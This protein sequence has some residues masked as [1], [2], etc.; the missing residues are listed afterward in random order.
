MSLQILVPLDGSKFAEQALPFARDLIAQTG[1]ILHL[2]K[3]HNPVESRMSGLLDEEFMREHDRAYLAEKVRDP[4]L[5]GVMAVSALL[6]GD[7]VSALDKYT[8]TCNIHLIVMSTHGRGGLTRAWLGSVADELIRETNIPVFLLRPEGDEASFGKPAFCIRHVLLPVDGSEYSEAVI[9]TAVTLGG[10]C[11]TSYTLL[12]VLPPAIPVGFGDGIPLPL[13]PADSIITRTN[14]EEHV[15][16]IAQDLAARGYRVRSEFI[17]H[18]DIAEA[19]RGYAR[20]NEVDL[21][22]MVT[23]SRSGWKRLALGSIADSIIRGSS[24]PVLVLH[25]EAMVEPVESRSRKASKTKHN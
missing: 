9:E 21:I 7:V 23:H 24:V 6:T 25:P 17:V 15:D 8:R 12:R 13:E 16:R 11:A 22:A 3:V 4:G 1:G 20:V 14:A 10:S 5:S 19:I 18:S 2:T